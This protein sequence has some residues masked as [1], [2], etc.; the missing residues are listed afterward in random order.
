MHF[1]SE[2]EI[3]NWSFLCELAFDR[4]L[5]GAKMVNSVI[6]FQFGG[7]KRHFCFV[8]RSIFSHTIL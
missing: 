8:A 5:S 7:S 3:M 6:P 1:L 4:R 2:R